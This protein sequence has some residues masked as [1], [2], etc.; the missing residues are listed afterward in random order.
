[1]AGGARTCRLRRYPGEAEF[2]LAVGTVEVKEEFL[3]IFFGRVIQREDHDTKEDYCLDRDG[4]SKD[5]PGVALPAFAHGFFGGDIDAGVRRHA[6][7]TLLSGQLWVVAHLL[8]A[9]IAVHE[10]V[11]GRVARVDTRLQEPASHPDYRQADADDHDQSSVHAGETNRIVRGSR[12]PKWPP[13]A[14][15][16]S[17]EL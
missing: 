3:N 2:S 17:A 5:P 9:L 14:N 8:A 12:G 1:V 11:I 6:A 4:D 15:A 7:G 10:P 13:R 16:Q